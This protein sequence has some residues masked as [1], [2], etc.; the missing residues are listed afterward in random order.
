MKQQQ[1]PMSRQEEIGQNVKYS[2]KMINQQNTMSWVGEIGQ[3][4][5]FWVKNVIFFI[6]TGPK[7]VKKYFP[8]NFHWPILVIDPK[9]GFYK[10][11]QQSPITGFGEIDQNDCFWA[12]MG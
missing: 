9:C 11:N 4:D 12:K 5:I 2:F 8:Q 1:N 10:E 3:N 7:M 6:K